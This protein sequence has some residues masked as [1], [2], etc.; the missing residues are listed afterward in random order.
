MSKTD[1][2]L[3]SQSWQAS[4]RVV[5]DFLK[6]DLKL[7]FVFDRHTRRLPAEV[8]RRVQYL[9]YGVVRNLGR[10]QSLLKK[11]VRKLPKKRLQAVMLVALFEWMD[12]EEAN[13]PL[14]V[15]HAVDQAKQMLSKPEAKFANAVLRKLPGVVN[16]ETEAENSLESLSNLY[17]HPQW[18]IQRWLGLWG[19]VETR[20]FLT[21]NQATPKIYAYSPVSSSE[22]PTDWVITPWTGFY[23]IQQADWMVIRTWLAEGKA[24]IQDP[25]TRLGSE[26]LGD[27]R[28]GTVLD[29]CAAP[30]GKSIQLLHRIEG[31]PAVLISVDLPGVRF[32]RLRENL[33]R[34]RRPGIQTSQVASDVL[35]LEPAD[36]VHPEYDVVYLDVPCSNTG[37][38]QRRPDIKWRLKE[39]SMDKL[40]E[41]QLSLLKKAALFVKLN[42]FV[43]YSTCSVDPD[44]NSGVV[45]AFLTAFGKAFVLR[46]EILSL[47]WQSGHDGAGAFL[48]QRIR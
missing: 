42:G 11:A 26:L 37:V 43:I 15:H 3:S 20:A 4:V 28:F 40:M 22:V 27:T 19:E 17:S 38:I 47:P 46:K 34:Y 33:V 31:D 1:K 48:L 5:E 32:E 18:L 44:E 6:A 41:L 24:Y 2:L 10:L 13:R 21:W 23:E 7:D 25:S 29:L 8:S 45:S 12:A 30:G 14:V 9:S 35:S 16:T 39:A 36:L